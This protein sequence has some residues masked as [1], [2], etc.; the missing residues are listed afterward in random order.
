MSTLKTPAFILFAL[1]FLIRSSFPSPI[2]F[3]D[4]DEGISPQETLDFL[5]NF[6]YLANSVGDDLQNLHN[7]EAIENAIGQL[8]T[9]AGIPATGK[10]DATTVKVT[11][12]TDVRIKY[13]I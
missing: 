4:D 12:H 11:G 6:G 3:P 5:H 13:H 10:L 9:F 1:N 2:T 7:Q 8:Q